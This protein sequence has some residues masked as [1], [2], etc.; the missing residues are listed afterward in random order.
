MQQKRAWSNEQIRAKEVRLID[1]HGNQ[2]GI[3]PTFKALE[4]ARGKELDLVQITD[5]SCPPVC[6]IVDFGKL[7]YEQEKEARKQKAKQKKVGTKGI[8]LGLNI[9][10]HDI[11]VRKMQAEKFI[12]EGNKV[13]VELMLRGREKA[14][15]EVGFNV[16]KKFINLLSEITKI[17]QPLKRQGG[18]LTVLLCPKK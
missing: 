3:M 18:K 12:S 17:E 6:K 1:E 5:A 9:G 11:G 16:V 14:H 7:R 2:V 4:M 13:Q 8:R 10:E 15:P